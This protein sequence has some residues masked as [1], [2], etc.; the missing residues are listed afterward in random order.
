MCGGRLVEPGGTKRLVTISRE[1]SM[2]M[3]R[4]G[5]FVEFMEIFLSQFSLAVAGTRDACEQLSGTGRVA[6][7]QS[8][9]GES[10]ND[11]IIRRVGCELFVQ[12]VILIK[13]GETVFDGISM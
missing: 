3:R 11:R 2:M 6:R 7:C 5:G 8:F 10:E 1:L 9:H 4:Q 13:A 12:I